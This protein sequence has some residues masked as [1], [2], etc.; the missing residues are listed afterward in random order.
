MEALS[1][2]RRAA[3]NGLVEGMVAVGD[4]YAG[5]FG[6]PKDDAE[7]TRWYRKAADAGDTGAMYTM[8]IRTEFGMGATKDSE[9]AAQWA[10]ASVKGG[11]EY[12][13]TQ[14]IAEAGKWSAEFRRALQRKLKEAGVYCGRHRRA[15]GRRRQRRAR[16]AGE[17]STASP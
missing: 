13:R 9:E 4:M 5:G 10:I 17:V 8:A 16:P 12:A 1:N 11:Y 2:Y 3:D 15:H 7:A 6:T 14:L